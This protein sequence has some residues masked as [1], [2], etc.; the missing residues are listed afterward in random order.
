M[1]EKLK[2]RKYSWQMMTEI[3]KIEVGMV[4]MWKG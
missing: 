2:S 3:V 1:I 4:L